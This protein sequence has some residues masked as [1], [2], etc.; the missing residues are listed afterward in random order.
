MFDL[1]FW[2]QNNSV[3]QPVK[4]N[5]LGSSNAS[6]SSKKQHR[7]KSRVACSTKHDQYNS[8]Q[9]CH[10]GLKCRSVRFWV[11]FLG[12]GCRRVPCTGSSGLLVWFWDEWNTSIT[13]SQRS[14]TGIPSIRKLASREIS[15]ASVELCETDVY[16]LHIQLLGTNVWLPKMHI[17]AHLKLILGPPSLQQNRS[18]E[19]VP[20]CT[21][22]LCFPHEFFAGIHLCGECLRSNVLAFATCFVPFCDSTSKF[23]HG[24]DIDL[25]CYKTLPTKSVA[26]SQV[27]PMSLEWPLAL[28]AESDQSSPS[29]SHKKPND[30]HPEGALPA[31]PHP[32]RKR[33]TLQSPKIQ[34]GNLDRNTC[35]HILDDGLRCVPG[36]LEVSLGL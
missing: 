11:R 26:C 1:D 23:V 36:I 31:P 34:R 30:E 28:P 19:T 35:V 25:T 21:V 4:N 13:N 12:L 15:S 7:T 32:R 29:S 22:V 17:R 14:K 10:V 16:F 9:T 2:I 3:K 5:S 27:G 33:D 24:H 18:P 20:I 8:N 6:L